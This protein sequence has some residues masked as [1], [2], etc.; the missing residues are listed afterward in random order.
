MSSP[1]PEPDPAALRKALDEA[2]LPDENVRVESIPSTQVELPPSDRVT[3]T[4]GST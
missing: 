3:D 2:G 4:D 1:L